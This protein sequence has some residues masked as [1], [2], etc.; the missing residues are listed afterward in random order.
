M[1]Q[2]QLIE[3]DT[4]GEPGALGKTRFDNNQ[5]QT[6]ETQSYKPLPTPALAASSEDIAAV[7]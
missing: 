7:T 4:R 6:R 5:T 2:G 3:S 1:K